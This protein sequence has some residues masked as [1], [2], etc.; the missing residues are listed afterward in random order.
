MATLDR[1]SSLMWPAVILGIAILYRTEI[2]EGISRLSS[3]RY[4]GF[5]VGF[6]EALHAAGDLAKVAAADSPPSPGAVLKE[7]DAG[8]AAH[9]P[10][11]D[12]LRRLAELSPRVAI[13]EAWH[14]VEHA[15][16]HARVASD[17]T[18][19]PWEP[20]FDRLHSLRNRVASAGAE[21]DNYLRPDQARQYADLA[22]DLIAHLRGE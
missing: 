13:L 5:E 6:S 12:R 11:S 4:R 3:V 15:G 7:L 19:S 20:L 22:H 2:R 1:L 8:P 9:S 10:S 18:A 16:A 21:I 14:E 17:P